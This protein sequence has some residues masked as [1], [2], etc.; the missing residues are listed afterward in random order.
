[1]FHARPPVPILLLTVAGF[2]TLYAPQPLLP[3]LARAFA[4]D[5]GAASLLIT[6]TMLPL[7]LAPLLYGYGLE[8]VPARG[9]LITAAL[10]LALC[11]TAMAFVEHWHA[12]LLLR[13]AVGLAL[14]ALFAALMTYVA[15]SADARS[16]RQALAWYVAATIAGGFS[17]RALSGLAAS[18]W[19]WRIALGMWGPVLLGM[20]LW[21][22][23]LPRGGR[24]GFG[25]VTPRVFVT[26]LEQ[27][28]LVQGYLAILAVF[29]V[30]AAVLN[31]L[32]FRLAHLH[33]AAGT[34]GIGFAYLGY[35]SGLVVALNAAGLRRRF[36][37]EGRLYLFG[38]L[39]YGLGL[40]LFSLRAFAGIYL[41]MFAFCGGMFLIHTR[42]S[43]HVN[44][45]AR[46]GK[47]VVN[48][49]Y[50][51]AYYLGGALGSW[52]PNELY[53]RAG[54]GPFLLVVAAMLLLA[55]LFLGWML[56]RGRAP[57]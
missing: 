2:C 14:P 36:G 18:V 20:A 40:A 43:G 23:H 24:S 35:L 38:M 16:V 48:G 32:P 57:A 3:V 54:W 21:T 29:F 28:G 9:M 45:L 50:I 34:S 13:V 39:L 49:V 46:A 6:V 55:G 12:L 51:A 15:E 53:R 8:A 41:A 1:M 7:A 44:Q 10:V 19:D 27:P 33:P 37:S 25:R 30:F 22:R 5:A 47:G 42:L 11:Q 26:L 31:T 56:R 17:G 4:V 52:L